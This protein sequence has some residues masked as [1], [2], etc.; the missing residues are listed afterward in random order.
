[1]EQKVLI[2]D[3]GCC[4]AVL[5][6]RIRDALPVE[7]ERVVVEIG[8]DESG[9][10]SAREGLY[11]QIERYIGMAEVIVIADPILALTILADLRSRFLS[12]KF[13]GYEGNLDELTKGAREI[14]I[15]APWALRRTEAY[16]RMKARCEHV[17]ITE[18]DCEKWLQATKYRN[19]L[20]LPDLSNEIKIGVRV[21]VLN[22]GLLEKR[23]RLEEIIGWR[24]ELI[25]FEEDI[26]KK[27]QKV[28]GLTK[29]VV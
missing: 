16:Q 8:R 22:E 27:V 15:L 26:T 24:G 10:I 21:L 23:D 12:Q 7:V 2:F 18:P 13:V 19:R 28:C 3:C 17:G 25:D 9:R 29:W 14:L 4:G 5:E 1:M 6:Q 20:T 11:K